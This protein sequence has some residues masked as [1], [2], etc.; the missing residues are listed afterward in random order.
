MTKRPALVG[1]L[2]LF[3]GYMWAWLSRTEKAVSGEMQTFIRQEQMQRLK[4]FLIGGRR[5]AF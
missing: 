2:G 4:R 1:G 5:K 3:S